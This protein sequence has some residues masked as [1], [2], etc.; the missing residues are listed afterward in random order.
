MAIKKEPICCPSCGKKGTWTPENSSRPF[1]S[2][3]C[4]L[5]DLSDWASEQ[6]KIPGAPVIVEDNIA[7]ENVD[8][9]HGEDK[10]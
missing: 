2:A 3:R 6:H 1:C 5:I 4:K 7:T 8:D 9:E 10:P